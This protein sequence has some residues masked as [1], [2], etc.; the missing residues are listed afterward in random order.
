[1]TVTSRKIPKASRKSL[2]LLAEL[3]R[4]FAKLDTIS[5]S[6]AK[7]LSDLIELAPEDALVLLVGHQVKFC[8]MIAWRR[9]RFDH[10]WT[11]AEVESLAG[12]MK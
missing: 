8:W 11:L 12:S 6:G 1:M 3:K 10:G 5:T 9:L 4:T 2:W 7:K